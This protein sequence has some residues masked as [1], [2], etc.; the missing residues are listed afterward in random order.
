MEVVT[1]PQR[2]HIPRYRNTTKSSHSG[3][4]KDLGFA[5]IQLFKGER[6]RAENK[7]F[8]VVLLFALNVCCVPL[9]DELETP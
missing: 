3:A 1:K 8:A 4:E 7:G 2:A 5:I 6:L 9:L